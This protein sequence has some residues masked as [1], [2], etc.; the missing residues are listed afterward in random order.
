MADLHSDAQDHPSALILIER[1]LVHRVSNL[2]KGGW[3]AP[4]L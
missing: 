3:K 4:L 1:T 2:V